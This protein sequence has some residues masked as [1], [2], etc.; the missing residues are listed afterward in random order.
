M[1][2]L[3]QARRKLNE[4]RLCAAVGGGDAASAKNR[5]LQLAPGRRS[6]FCQLVDQSLY[7]L[8]VFDCFSGEMPAAVFHHKDCC[9]AKSTALRMGTISALRKSWNTTRPAARSP[10]CTQQNASNVPSVNWNETQ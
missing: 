1:S 5:N 8:S 3:N 7:A 9:H 4:K 2:A 6:F 10:R